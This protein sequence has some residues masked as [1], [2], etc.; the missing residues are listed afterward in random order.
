MVPS[1]SYVTVALLLGLKPHGERLEGEEPSEA[2]RLWRDL[3]GDQCSLCT[4]Y[5]MHKTW[6]NLGKRLGKRVL[7]KIVLTFLVMDDVMEDHRA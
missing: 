5:N 6:E 3:K 2:R 1:A 7:G 4:K